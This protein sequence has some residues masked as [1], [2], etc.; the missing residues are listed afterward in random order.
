MQ[1][2]ASR[3]LSNGLMFDTHY[4]WSKN[5][6]NTDN[7]ADNQGFNAGG[8]VGNNHLSD[9]SKNRHLGMSDVPHRFVATV[10]YE[11][12][13]GQG[14]PL[15]PANAVFRAIAGGWQTSS[16]IIAQAGTPIA[17]SGATD[18]AVLGRPDRI[19]GVPIEV[20]EE[21]QRWYDGNTS[22]TLPNGRVI[23]PSRNTF[24]KYYSGAFQ[25]RVVT[26]PNGSTVIDRFW[27]GDGA[28]VYDDIRTPGRF[29]IDL[30]LRRTF[31]VREGLNLEI[32]A[33]ATNLFNSIQLRGAHT[34]ALGATTT[35]T[36]ASRGLRPGMAGSDTFGTIGTTT[37]DPRQIMMRAILRF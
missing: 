26:T 5:I 7:M 10:L 30:G 25:G 22:V 3:N 28:P 34:G 37:F 35:T 20:P 33:D 21:L 8:T 29:N 1:L 27:W 19:A 2:R 24:L 16:T 17:I 14:K 36:S 23:T 13:F 15:N 4:T 32:G 18:G 11:L 9:F 6:D 31:R 12:P